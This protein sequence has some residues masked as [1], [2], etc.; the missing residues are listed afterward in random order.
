MYGQDIMTIFIF[1][2]GALLC[3]SSALFFPHRFPWVIGLVDE[4][5]A[6]IAQPPP[7]DSEVSALFSICY[8]LRQLPAHIRVALAQRALLIKNPAVLIQDLRKI[9][10]H[11]R[12]LEHML[13][14]TIFRSSWSQY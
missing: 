13:R 8:L 11:F 9:T 2:C 1:N 6:K 12:H 7:Y 4:T 5:E 14:F 10:F 3:V